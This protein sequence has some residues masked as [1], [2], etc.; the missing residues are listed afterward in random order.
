MT[1][2]APDSSQTSIRYRPIKGRPA[3]FRSRAVRIPRP[4]ADNPGA[5]QPASA[6]QPAAPTAPPQKAVL[7]EWHAM[8]AEERVRAWSTLRDW[9]TW[10]HDRYELSTESRLPHCWVEHPGLI[11]ELWALMAWREEIYTNGQPG[12]QGQAARYWHTEMRNLVA[13]AASFYAAGCRA[14]HRTAEPL[15]TNATSLQESWARADAMAGIPQGLLSD[16]A[17]DTSLRI[18]A[19]T[20]ATAISRGNAKLLSPSIPEYAHHDGTWWLVDGTGSWIR[21]THDDFAASLDESAARMAQAAEAARRL[22]QARAD[23]S[24]RNT[25]AGKQ[26]SRD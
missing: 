19:K 8:S 6:P 12:A 21:V 1:D 7:V 26:G 20:M 17:A 15:T 5:D 4:S 2:P 24:D 9:V 25:P 13:A 11:E 22:E 23:Q 16:E 10:L 18:S 14:G 3:T